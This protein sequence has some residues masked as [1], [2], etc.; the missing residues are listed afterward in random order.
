[1]RWQYGDGDW[2]QRWR[3]SG[4]SVVRHDR[5][6]GAI[7]ANMMSTYAGL[8]QAGRTLG[9]SGPGLGASI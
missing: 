8:L 2:S 5:V 7:I 9:N 3:C 1:M 4:G 6:G